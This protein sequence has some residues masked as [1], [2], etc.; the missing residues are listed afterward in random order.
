VKKSISCPEASQDPKT[1][2]NYFHNFSETSI[3]DE[4]ITNH[5]IIDSDLLQG[6]IACRQKHGFFVDHFYEKYLQY[7]K[8]KEELNPEKMQ[9]F[10]ER[11]DSIYKLIT[12]DMFELHKRKMNADSFDVLADLDAT[13]KRLLHGGLFKKPDNDIDKLMKN[14][15]QKLDSLFSDKY[16]NNAA[17]KHVMN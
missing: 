11:W 17:L 14:F 5:H 4:L 9:E 6:F 12:Q 10:T 8:L 1:L 15:N 3:K 2:H 16:L 13:M 7:K